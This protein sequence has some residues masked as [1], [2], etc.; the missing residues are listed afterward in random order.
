MI[1]LGKYFPSCF[2]DNTPIPQGL[3]IWTMIILEQRSGVEAAFVF[4]SETT[5]QQMQ[6]L[7]N[8]NVSHL[9]IQTRNKHGCK[10]CIIYFSILCWAKKVGC[11]R[12]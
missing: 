9:V 8:R 6:K 10:T 11:M 5:N 4:L 1:L 12:T 3:S 7:A 2:F